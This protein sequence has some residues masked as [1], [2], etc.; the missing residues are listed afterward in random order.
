[1]VFEYLDIFK[2][3]Q[4]YYQFRKKENAGFSF[5]SWAAELNF[6]SRSYL[7]MVILG[8]KKVSPQF[9]TRFCATAGFGEKEIKYFLALT[10][11][12]QS[13][14]QDEKQFY[15]QELIK[16]LKTSSD[17]KTVS[18]AIEFLS[19]PLYARL[20][21]ML[22]FEDILPITK[23]FARLMDK[24]EA[25]IK[26]ALEKLEDLKL[27]ESIEVD[28]ESHWRTSHTK[29]DVPDNFGSVH[30]MRFHEASLNESIAA[31]HRPK[32]LR[33]YKSLILPV[34]DLELKEFYALIEDFSA[35][36]LARFQSNQYS[37]RRL[38][39]VNMNI[40]P[41]AEADGE[42]DLGKVESET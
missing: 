39:Q 4:D 41:V 6:S 18:D 25:E 27:A 7:R 29:F 20:L 24:T 35:Q 38:F 21:V 11:Y 31:F 33:K 14:I 23:T 3:L 17:R 10:K 40:F 42:A 28:G 19:Q 9:S 13:G 22:G 8:K 32:E 34:S 15:G 5:E 12:S 36:Q 37:G 2:F 16:I 1:M 30:L 26:A